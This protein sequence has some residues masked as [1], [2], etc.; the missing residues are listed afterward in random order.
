MRSMLIALSSLTMAATMTAAPALAQGTATQAPAGEYVLDRPHATL[1]WQGLHNGLSWYSARFTNFDVKLTFDPTDV[2]K[3]RVTATIDP[4]S[5][6]TDYARTRPAGSTTDF[7]NELATG[8]KFFN[9]G[10]FPAITFTSTAVTKTG[11]NTGK[12]TG[13]LTFL[14][15]TKPVTLDVTYIG[16]RNDPRA[17][18]HKVG[19]QAVGT[20]N[21]TQWGMAAGGPIADNIKI[22]INAELVQK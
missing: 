18:K 16:N 14:G 10:K 4:K 13:N 2:T 19:F 20:I 5:V 11:A 12:M 6:E 22:E 7:N 3:S 1:E 17:Q 15:V 8:E 9:A 21:K